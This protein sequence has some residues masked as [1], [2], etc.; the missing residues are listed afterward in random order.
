MQEWSQ[1]TDKSLADKVMSTF[2]TKDMM[3]HVP[4]MS[5]FL[6]NDF[7]NKI[8]DFGN[9]HGWVFLVWFILNSLPLE[10]HDPFQ[11]NYNTIG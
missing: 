6:S 9:E 7:S 4:S 11:M 5:M 3:D 1:T 2:T 8:K 10:Q